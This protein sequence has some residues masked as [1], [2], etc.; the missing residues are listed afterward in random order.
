MGPS[1]TFQDTKIHKSKDIHQDILQS[2]DPARTTK[3]HKNDVFKTDEIDICR[4]YATT[5]IH[6]HIFTHSITFLTILSLLH[7]HRKF[8]TVIISTGI[9]F[10]F[11]SA[12]FFF[13]GGR[14]KSAYF[15]RL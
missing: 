2:V 6:L 15:R 3:M 11:N 10:F 4:N 12:T 14:D 5:C 8:R 9:N 7:V 13:G 1:D